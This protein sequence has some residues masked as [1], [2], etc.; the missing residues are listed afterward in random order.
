MVLLSILDK[1]E[2]SYLKKSDLYNTLK[3]SEDEEE[4]ELLLKICPINTKDFKLFI[5]VLN[6]W[7]PYEYPDEFFDLLLNKKLLKNNKIVVN[8]FVLL[9]QSNRYNFFLEILNCDNKI[10]NNKFSLLSASYGYIDF[11]KYLFKNKYKIDINITKESAKNGHL[12]YLKYINKYVSY[13]SYTQALIETVS[14]DRIDCLK[15]LYE[16]LMYKYKCENIKDLRLKILDCIIVKDSI[17]CLE[18]LEYLLKYDKDNISFLIKQSVNYGSIKCLK[19]FLNNYILEFPENI[20]N[21]AVNNENIDILI[22]LKSYEFVWNI[23]N[24]SVATIKGNLNILKY[25]HETECPWNE[26]I[27]SYAAFYG[28]I[29][30]LI[31]IHENGCPWDKDTS[32][33]AAH[34]ENIECLKYAHENGCPWD[35]DTCATAS[36]Y[37]NLEALT[38]AHENGCPWNETS[39]LQASSIKSNKNLDCLEYLIKNNCPGYKK[40]EQVYKNY[41]KNLR[42]KKFLSF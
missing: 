23:D 17:K 19:L 40:Y 8:D 24:Y 33:S 31:Y 6:F 38:Y 20:L 30:C 15:Y 16:D 10:N 11:F 13:E 39:F 34:R 18:Y 27:P 21:C 3:S 42:K 7:D 14:N 9:N 41:V 36:K 12:T 2:Y 28:W 32:S 26:D 5:E 22:L 4:E 25:M 1:E 35:E 37:G 29:E